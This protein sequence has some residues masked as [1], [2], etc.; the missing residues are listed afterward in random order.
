ML[1]KIYNS[2]NS[3]IN[4]EFLSILRSISFIT[5]FLVSAQMTFNFLLIN[6]VYPQNFYEVLRLICAS[7]VSTI[8][9]YNQLNS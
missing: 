7:Y 1:Q 3:M 6:T 4:N 5:Y 9:S 2:A 8:P